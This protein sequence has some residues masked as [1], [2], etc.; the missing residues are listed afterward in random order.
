MI[1]PRPMFEISGIVGSIV[2]AYFVVRAVG[3][4]VDPRVWRLALGRTRSEDLE[5]KQGDL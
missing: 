4:I 2:V 3:T 5:N 1:I